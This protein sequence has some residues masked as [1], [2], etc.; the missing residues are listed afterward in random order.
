M[1][2]WVPI[3]AYPNHSKV[4]MIIFLDA[5]LACW[6]RINN[7]PMMNLIHVIIFVE[8]L[9]TNNMVKHSFHFI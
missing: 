9:C 1:V 7:V 2:V 4:E 5:S 6:V 8:D 3:V